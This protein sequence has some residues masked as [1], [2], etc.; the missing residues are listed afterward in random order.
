MNDLPMNDLAMNDLPINESYLPINDLPMLEDLGCL[1]GKSVLARVDFN[2]PISRDSVTGEFN[3]TDHMRIEAAVPTLQWLQEQGASVTAMTHLGRPRLIDDVSRSIATPAAATPHTQPTSAERTHAIPTGVT[4]THTAI[5]HAMAHVEPADVERFSVEP[6][7]KSL[8]ELAPGVKLLENLRFHAGETACDDRF[9][10]RMVQGYDFYVNDAFG[11]SHRSHASVVGPPRF[12]PSAAGRLLSHE[13]RVL[14]RLRVSPDRPFVVVLGGAKVSDKLDLIESLLGVVD[15]MVIGGAM[16]FT[17]IKAQGG[18]VGDSLCE[19]SMTEKCQEL[20]GG[21][22]PIHLP[23]DIRALSP[24]GVL[25]DASAGGDVEQFNSSDLPDGWKGGDI[26]HATVTKFS[27]VISNAST[28]LWNGPMGMFEDHRFVHGT[29]A[30]ADA[31]VKTQAFTVIGGGDSAAAVNHFGFNSQ[32]DH[33][34]TGGGAAL[35][36]LEKGDLPGLKALRSSRRHRQAVQEVIS[37]ARNDERVN[38][39]EQ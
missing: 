22:V 28:V 25:G 30:V 10:S 24:D 37:S 23:V 17:F 11:V 31:M 38:N 5:P 12:L 19:D 36:L 33:V 14:S 34:S 9:I 32:I 18:A 29:K 26:G 16:C 7:R 20:M 1:K 27:Q 2:V 39:C 3:I 13:V 35:E 6:I 15:A 4:P 21:P 8:A